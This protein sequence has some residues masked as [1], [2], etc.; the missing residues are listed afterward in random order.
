MSFHIFTFKF[1]NQNTLVQPENNDKELFIKMLVERHIP[2][3]E[4][5]LPAKQNECNQFNLMLA[6]IM[7]NSELK[8]AALAGSVGPVL[9]HFFELIQLSFFCIAIE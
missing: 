1:F 7:K 9:S 2:S 5:A 3:L 8:N 4:S 6:S